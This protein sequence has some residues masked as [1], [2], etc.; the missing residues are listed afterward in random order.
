MGPT[1]INLWKC[2]VTSMAPNPVKFI[3][4]RDFHSPKLYKSIWIDAIH[5]PNPNP[6]E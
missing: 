4:C 1:P 6:N 5:N 3:K 2:L